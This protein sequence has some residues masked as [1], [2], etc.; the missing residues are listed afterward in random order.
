MLTG[1]STDLRLQL[2]EASGR[3]VRTRGVAALTTREI[4]REAG[5]S[6]G[7]LYKHFPSKSDL[8]MA[9]CQE[10]LPDLRGQ[11]GDLTS[12]VGS[13]TVQGN[14]EELIRATQAFMAEV[15]PIITA[16]AADHELRMRHRSRFAGEVIPPRRTVE[17]LAGYIAAEQRI[18]RVAA[19][20]V[21]QVFAAMLAGACM[22]AATVEYVFG[23]SGHGLAAEQYARELASAL[24]AGMAP[25]KEEGQHE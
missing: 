13:G 3:L 2:I 12:R 11:I 8:L 19:S 16:V 15:V 20:V 17:A 4:A 18:G 9:Y 5:C 7:A 21:P 25:R 24:W 6:D 23:D 10:C 14:L 22:S 1:Q